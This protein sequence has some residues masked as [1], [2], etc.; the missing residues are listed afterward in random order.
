MLGG[1]EWGEPS[2]RFVGAG[3]RAERRRRQTWCAL[4]F[5][6]LGGS[7]APARSALPPD[8]TDTLVA[9]VGGPTALA[10]LPDGRLLVAQQGGALRMIKNGALLATPVLDLGARVC[11]NSERGLLG[12]AVDPDFAQNRLVYLYY[13]FNRHQACPTGN[14]GSPLNPNNRVSR[15]VMPTGSDRLDPA[16]EIVLIDNLP[17]PAGNHNGGDLQFGPDALLYVSVGD[18]GCDYALDSGCAGGNDAARDRHALAGKILRISRDGEI[19]E[20]NPFTGAGSARC[21]AAGRSEPGLI[22]REIFATGLRNPFRI[23]FDPGSPVPRFFIND[24]GQNAVEEIDDGLR[25]ADYGWNCREGNQTNNTA[26]PCA[27]LPGGLVPPIFAYQHDQPIPWSSGQG[28]PGN[29]PPR[30]CNSIT[31]GAF[32]PAGLWPGYDGAY[33]FG[34][35]VCGGIFALRPQGQGFAPEDFATALGEGSAVTLRFGPAAEKSLYYTTYAGGGQVRRIAH[36]GAAGNHPPVAAATASPLAGPAPL[37]VTFDARASFDPDPGDTLTYVWDF[38]TGAPLFNTSNPVFVGTYQQ[39][40]TYDVTLRVRDNHQAE[41]APVGLQISVGNSPPVPSILAPAPSAR[42]AVGQAVT[43]QGSATD[44]EDGALPGSALSWTVLLHHNDDHTHPFLGPVA[45]ATVQ[46][47]APAPEDLA[48]AVGSHLEIRLTATDSLG[49]K[50]TVTQLFQPRRTTLELHTAPTGLR[51]LANGAAFTAPATVTSW[52]SYQVTV[53]APAAQAAGGAAY[54]FE[55]WSDGGARRHALTTPAAGATLTA[56]F[57]SPAD[58]QLLLGAARFRVAVAW[59][60]AAA[61]GAGHAL[62]L[63]GDSGVFWFFDQDNIELIVKVLDGCGLNDRYWVFAGGLTNV[64][65]TLS[66]LDLQTGAVKTYVNALGRP[67]API[68]DTSAFATCR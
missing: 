28:W 26:G 35:F 33:L 20:D 65:T 16:S 47:T 19:P 23:A 13:T 41:S 62:A 40:G 9:T 36:T 46:L 31:G 27:P 32:V 44:P 64:E 58:A 11:A 57:S 55:S 1:K 59:K 45:G 2:S 34:D 7:T 6:L 63:T 14:P 25:G 22:C 8:F 15:F 21:N 24:V 30:R 56:T 39:A 61:S 4:L 53:E 68:Q 10:F 43:L 29:Q 5:C 51:I 52:E 49:L 67:F 60:T 37:V 3:V 48:A 38:D 17:S 50:S 54:L 12:V 42:F 18:G 66:V